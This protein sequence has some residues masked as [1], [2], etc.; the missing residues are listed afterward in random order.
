MVK[1][2]HRANVTPTGLVAIL[3]HEV[4]NKLRTFRALQKQ[5]P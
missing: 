2:R 5:Q 4:A 3:L 1:W